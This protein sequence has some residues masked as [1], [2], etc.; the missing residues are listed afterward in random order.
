LAG[1][2]RDVLAAYWRWKRPADWPFPGER[3]GRPISCNGIFQ[4]CQNA[5]R[6]ARITKP[7]HPH[8]LRHAFATHLLDEGVSLLVI[9]RLL[10]HAH[11]KTTALYLHLSDSAV[12][13]TRSPLEALDSLDLV[14]A[15]SP[16]R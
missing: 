1:P 8:S 15:I 2:L 6:R 13:S 9:Q 16:E 3:P 12:R 5:A 10:G 14:C 4:L 7:V 11:L